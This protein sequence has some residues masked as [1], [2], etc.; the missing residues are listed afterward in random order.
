MNAD[1]ER[2]LSPAFDAVEKRLIAERGSHKPPSR[3][4][5][6]ATFLALLWRKE[7]PVWPRRMLAQAAGYAIKGD[8][9]KAV[10]TLIE[11]GLFTPKIRTTTGSNAKGPSIRRQRYLV[12]NPN[13]L[14]LVCSKVLWRT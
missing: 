9:D 10:Q 6:L 1:Q 12:P 8:I 14:S 4:A 3:Q 11:S 13:L 5:K 7:Q 2:R